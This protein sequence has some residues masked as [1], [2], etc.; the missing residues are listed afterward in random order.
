MDGGGPRESGGKSGSNF[1]LLLRI[2]ESLGETTPIAPGF[3]S[4]N[5]SLSFYSFGFLEVLFP[6]FKVSKLR[7]FDC[8]EAKLL[9][10]NFLAKAGKA[11]P[12][13][14]L[15]WK[16]PHTK[17]TA[18]VPRFDFKSLTSQYEEGRGGSGPFFFLP[19]L[20]PAS[21]RHTEGGGGRLD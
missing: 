20:D 3:H 21:N 5:I 18:L 9:L 16:F 12:K 19:S 11:Q 7:P 10:A 4:I 15:I 8:F 1:S 17:A 13:V 6:K 14:S 2:C